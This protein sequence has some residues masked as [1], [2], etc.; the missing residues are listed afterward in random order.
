MRNVLSSAAIAVSA[1]AMLLM[2]WGLSGNSQQAKTEAAFRHWAVGCNPV[3]FHYDHT[4]DM[5]GTRA[6][7][8]TCGPRK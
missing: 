1:L 3:D 4:A 8:V 6:F 2:V 7:I 5:Q